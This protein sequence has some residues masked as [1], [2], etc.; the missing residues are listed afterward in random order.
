MPSIFE[1]V[2]PVFPVA[3]NAEPMEEQEEAVVPPAPARPRRQDRREIAANPEP[4]LEPAESR[5]E[6]RSLLPQPGV[7][8]VPAAP[9][10]QAPGLPS[11][12]LAG[13]P[14]SAE[15]EVIE[16]VVR[17]ETPARERA[18]TARPPAASER[19]EI[20]YRERETRVEMHAQPAPLAANPA[21]VQAPLRERLIQ[22]LAAALP[23]ESRREPQP[24]T[25]A[26]R[27]TEPEPVIHVSIGRIEVRAVSEGPR[28]R[29]EKQAPAVMSLDEYLRSR[30][31]GAAR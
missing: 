22:P 27:E 23:K 4:A 30:E 5:L 1:P 15:P 20:L 13:V 7:S 29:A 19:R 21:I 3:G 6:T 26:A 14:R 25:T 16:R 24:S 2:S 17:G 10:T 18:P 28:P 12:L 9:A 8:P 31:R 11:Q